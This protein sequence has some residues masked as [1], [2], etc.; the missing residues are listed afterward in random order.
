MHCNKQDGVVSY[1]ITSS[2]ATSSLSSTV[3][4]SDFACLDVDYQL[5]LGRVS[6]RIPA[7]AELPVKAKWLSEIVLTT[8]NAA[9]IAGAGLS[10]GR[11]AAAR[12][13]LSDNG[14]LISFA[15]VQ[16]TAGTAQRL[17]E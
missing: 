17:V 12:V 3:R 8:H 2:A 16:T 9:K 1:S 14:G 7:R 4:P 11:L 5:E 10:R 6:G 13:A 15:P